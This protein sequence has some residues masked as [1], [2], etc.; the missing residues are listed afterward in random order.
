MEMDKKRIEYLDSMRGFTMI[1]VVLGHVVWYGLNY[2]V[3]N[4]FTYTFYNVFAYLWMPLFFFVSGFMLYKKDFAWNLSVARDFIIKK[5]RVLILSTLI[6]FLLFC[7]VQDKNVMGGLL[8]IYKYGYWFTIALFEFFLFY[9]FFQL[10]MKKII[11]SWM[12][13][14]FYILYLLFII[15]LSTSTTQ[16]LLNFNMNIVVITGFTYP[17]IQY[18][19]FFSFG[20]FFKKYF[21]VFI[22]IID[23]G[24]FF[25]LI[26]ILFF[27]GAI[28]LLRT[29]INNKWLD[30]ISIL[31]IG[32]IGI[33]MV[34]GVFYKH[35]YR[36]SNATIIGKTLQ[37]IGKRTLDIY[38]LHYFFMTYHLVPI[39]LWFQDNP[40]PSI[41]LLFSLVLS[42]WIIVLCLIVSYVLRSSHFLGKLLFGLK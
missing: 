17:L 2:P 42:L 39:G 7:Y 22:R 4:R 41:D 8:S 21:N 9:A 11:N 6:F 36:F 28:F 24:Y 3:D 14:I 32:I 15:M 30:M 40:N 13:N 34:Y 16:D 23:N 37:Y 33:I 29:D 19:V 31:F 27:G 38:L 20:I 10:L 5:I 12:R 25:A 26:L 1:L 35:Q 18:I